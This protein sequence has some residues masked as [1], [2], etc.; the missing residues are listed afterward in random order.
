[1]SKNKSRINSLYTTEYIDFTK[2]PMFFGSGKNTQR[3]DEMKYEYFDKSNDKMQ[4]LDWTFDEVD[5][6]Q[7]KVDF[8]TNMPSHYK[9]IYTKDLQKLIFLDSL[10]GRGPFLTLGQIT[11]LPELENAILTWTYFEG[12]KHSKTYTHNLR[13]VYPNPSEIFDESFN[14]AELMKIAD[15]IKKPFDDLYKSVVDYFYRLEND[16]KISKD[17]M[18]DLR[19]KTLRLIVEINILE[20]IRFYTGFAMIWAM[21]EGQNFVNGTSRNLKLICRDENQH[22]ALTQKMLQLLRKDESNLFTE[23]Y[24]EM[25]EEIRD[26]YEAV[27]YEE[28]DWVDFVF[29]EG[30]VIGLNEDILKLYLKYLT[31]KRYKAIGGK[32]IFDGV[33][34]DPLPWI[35]S[36][37]NA[38]ANEGLPQEQEVTNYVSGG[39]SKTDRA[40]TKSLWESV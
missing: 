25:E 8:N 10:Q 19:K 4:G 32:N 3:F 12:A 40:E 7:D 29:S 11:T 31:N 38:D 6:T 35:D 16:M 27:Y 36:Y 13:S 14:I 33:S 24:A 18:H 21:S 17:Y 26:R 30:S 20:G 37:I 1:M 2:E 22:L 5:M 9:F 39:I 15:S 28:A 23:V 34:T